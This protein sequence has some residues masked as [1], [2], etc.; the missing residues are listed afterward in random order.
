MKPFGCTSLKTVHVLYAYAARFL[1]LSVNG[2]VGIRTEKALR[3]T[4]D[5]GRS[6]DLLL[7]VWWCCGY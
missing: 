4:L 6:V 5:R 1:W 2:E 7:N 3:S